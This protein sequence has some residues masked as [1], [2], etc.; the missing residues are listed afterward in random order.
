MSLVED[1]FI[2]TKALR[3]NDFKSILNGTTANNQKGNYV[4][5]KCSVSQN[6]REE[7]LENTEFLFQQDANYLTDISG[8]CLNILFSCKGEHDSWKDVNFSRTV[9]EFSPLEHNCVVEGEDP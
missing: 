5:K 9:K 1:V 8:T 4:F 6:L 3:G 2:N 7:C